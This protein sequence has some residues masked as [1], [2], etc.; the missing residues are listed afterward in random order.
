MNLGHYETF[1]CQKTVLKTLKLDFLNMA[2]WPVS[3][4][5]QTLQFCKYLM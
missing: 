4:I 3:V 1:S 5:L 2:I